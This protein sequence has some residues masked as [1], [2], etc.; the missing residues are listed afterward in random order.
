MTT[1]TIR[2]P[3]VLNIIRRAARKGISVKCAMRTSDG[4]TITWS[5]GVVM[6]FS[7]DRYTLTR[8]V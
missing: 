1:Q 6:F 2:K 8:S 3:S 7:Q 5:N 4:I